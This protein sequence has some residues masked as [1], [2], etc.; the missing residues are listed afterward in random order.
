VRTSALGVVAAEDI[1]V[2]EGLGQY[3]GV[4]EHVSMS[5]RDRPRNSG[6]RLV[7]KTLVESPKQPVCVA[8]NAE[9]MG[10]MTRFVNHSCNPTGEFRELANGR[11]TTVVI[12]ATRFIR[13][14]EEITVD[15]DDDLWFVCRCQYALCRHR[16]IQ[17]EQDP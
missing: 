5:R 11:R 1:V 2:G 16:D 10:C 17:D 9:G 14:G 15:Y 6:Y 7:M 4:M 12:T 8:I 13:R 3:L